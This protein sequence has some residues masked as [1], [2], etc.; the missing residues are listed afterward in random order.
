MADQHFEQAGQEATPNIR[1]TR[2][3]RLRRRQ[4]IPFVRLLVAYI[5]DVRLLVWEARIPLIGFLVVLSTGTFYLMHNQGFDFWR[6]LYE[7]MTMLVL[8]QNV[9]FPDEPLGRLLFFAIPTFGL[10]FVFQGVLDFGR[11]LLDKSSRREA[12]QVSL[13]HTY[14]NHIV[15]C[16]LGRVSYRVMLQLLESRYDVV[17]IEQE[18]ESEFVPAA[19]ALQVPVI[20]G[21]ARDRHVLEQAGLLRARSLL[22]GVSNDLASIE[23]G[24]AARRLRPGL[25]VVLR[26]FNE[27]LDYNLERSKF[28]PNSAFSSSMV[29][30]PTLAA[31][32]VCRGI[33]YAV[34]LPDQL[35]GISE[36]MVTAGGQ[37]DN[38]VYKIEQEFRVRVLAYT[39][40]NAAGEVCWRRHVN[41]TAR[42]FGGDRLLLLGSLHH[43]GDVWQHGQARNKIMTTLGMQV[44]QRP[45]DQHNTVLVCGLGKVG[46]RVVQALHQMT[47]R[48]EIVVICDRESSRERFIKETRDLGIHILF[49]DA[50]SEEVLREAGLERAYSVAAVTSNNLSNLRIGLTVRHIRS[51]IHL[52]LRVFSDV[53]ADQLEDMFGIHTAFST[54]ALAAPTL[55]AAAVLKGT[56]YAIDIGEQLMSTARLTVREGDQFAGQ[57]IDTLRQHHAI[58]VIALRREGQFHL[59]PMDPEA[60]AQLFARPLLPGD[61]IIV[62]AEIHTIARLRRLGAKTDVTGAKITGRLPP[63]PVLPGGQAAITDQLPPLPSAPANGTAADEYQDL[64]KRLLSKKTGDSE[65]RAGQR[66]P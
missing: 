51:D 11:L 20:H 29:A 30:A 48:P 40:E 27:K 4:R 10:A 65:R 26:I 5:H 49:G 1:E 16:G 22:T 60:P 62:L 38:L 35:L 3:E 64:L 61:E 52:V 17:V 39:G 9:D 44:R 43:L 66:Q 47:P 18:W 63:L 19:L 46:F 31:A 53:L 50:R 12:W 2:Q 28:G 7:T 25:H 37:L 33:S 54:S 34:P 24:L 32:A 58:V 6:A 8:E 14:S 45:T 36:I 59:L 42:L 57:H 15:L 23:I 13:A 56:G 55:S 41:P 21:D